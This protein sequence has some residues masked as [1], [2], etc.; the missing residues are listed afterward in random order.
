MRD[1]EDCGVAKDGGVKCGLWRNGDDRGLAYDRLA[2]FGVKRDVCG[3]AQ[4]GVTTHDVR[5]D[6]EVFCGPKEGVA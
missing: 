1:D 4:D 5:L 3:A 2:H 6:A